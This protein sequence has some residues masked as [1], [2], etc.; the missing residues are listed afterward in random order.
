MHRLALRATVFSALCLA[1]AAPAW[2]EESAPQPP[3]PPA[4]APQPPA[5]PQP[6]APPAKVEVKPG[7]A[8]RDRAERERA[9]LERER[10]RVERDRERALERAARARDRE[11]ERA[12]RERERALEHAEHARAEMERARVR[13]DAIQA[14]FAKRRGYLG[15]VVLDIGGKLRAHYG[16]AADTGVLVSDVVADGPAQRAGVAVGDVLVSIGGTKVA[17]SNDVRRLVS[18][19]KEG[20]EVKL[21]VLRAGKPLALTARVIER[22]MPQ[23]M[24]DAMPGPECVPAFDPDAVR[25]MVERKIELRRGESPERMDELER[26][27]KELQDKLQKLQEKLQGNAG[28]LIPSRYTA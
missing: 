17:T 19:A 15:V 6:P 18:D 16:A 8:A 21:S 4:I 25:E 9:R 24:L 12:Q 13:A 7:D 10:Q 3:T 23:V 22:E 20:T 5:V 14:V 2:A 1:V 27:L 28:S 26:R 11:L